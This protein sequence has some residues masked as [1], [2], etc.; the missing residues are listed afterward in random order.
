MIRRPPRSTLFPYTTLFRSRTGA[1]T[2]QDPAS[3]SPRLGLSWLPLPQWTFYA[4]A[5]RS[6]RPNVGIDVAGAGFS[7][8][9]GRSMELGAKW[10]SADQRMGATAALFRSEERRVG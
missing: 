6:F 3:T 4:N 1:T 5:G 10:E 8:E 2:Q 9:S 7:P